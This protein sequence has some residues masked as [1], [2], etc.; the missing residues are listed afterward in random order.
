MGHSHQIFPNATSTVPQFSLPLVDKK[1]G[2]VAGIPALMAN[3]WGQHLGV[4]QMKL[5]WTG[6]H[7]E[8]DRSQTIIESRPIT[9][10]CTGGAALACSA[11]GKWKN[12]AACSFATAC[13]GQPDKTRV[14]VDADASVAALV[15]SEHQAT[16]SY[17][18]TPIGT[19][20]FGMSS[21]FAVVG[22][23]SA[24]Q[25]VNQAQTDYVKKY[26]AT[27]LPQYAALPVLSVSAPFKSGFQGGSDYTDVKAGN[28]AINNAADLYIFAN[29]LYA[30]KITGAQLIDWLEKSALLF[31]QIDPAK[32]ANQE[33]ISPSFPGYNFDA[34][35]D[36]DFHYEI[37]VTQP[38]PPMGQKAQGRIVN[39]TYKGAPLDPAAEFVVATNNYRAT[40]GGGFPGLDGSNVIIAS[41]DF[42]RD[43][44]I[45]YV[46]T[47]KNLTRAANGSARSWKFKSVTVAGKVVFKSAKD[48]LPLAAAAGLTNVSLESP[49]VGDTG[50]Q[51]Y[52]VD[53]S[54]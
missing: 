44:L 42:S 24:I 1:I 17:V 22:D 13:T 31:N 25:I 36:P 5:R 21:Y 54:K 28:I 39:V 35:T 38:L 8:V 20:D 51:S 34:I 6:A 15:D 29:T 49:D 41:P 18:K 52:A 26:I 9:T 27:N 12:G 14:Y 32:T 10:T 16:I 53:L 45:N 19:T 47:A 11:G 30:V 23:P 43:V 48:M 7:W 2:S 3:F 37:D 33:L 4:M 50:L 40:G 46:K